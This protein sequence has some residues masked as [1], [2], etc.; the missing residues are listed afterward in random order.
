MWIYILLENVKYLCNYC[1]LQH[2]FEIIKDK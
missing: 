2:N 1:G